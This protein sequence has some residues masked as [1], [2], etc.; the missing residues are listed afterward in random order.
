LVQSLEISKN[1]LER[2]KQPLNNPQSLFIIG[3]IM[4]QT[5]IDEHV[6]LEEFFKKGMKPRPDSLE[7]FMELSKYGLNTE[8]AN[9]KKIIVQFRFSGA[10][11]ASCY[12]TVEKGAITSTIGISDSY[13]IAIETPFELWMDIMTGKAD[14]GEMFMQRKYQVD[15]DLA[16][17]LALFKAN[18]NQ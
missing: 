15:G 6:T 16:M 7:G 10:V 11:E 1:T 8:I 9:D 17:M 14:G 2:I 4:W 18:A 3:N 12:F 5:C 13:D